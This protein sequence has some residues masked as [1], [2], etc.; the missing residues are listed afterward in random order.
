MS[1]RR[2]I[3]LLLVLCL[4]R[5]GVMAAAFTQEETGVVTA[6][7]DA[8]SGTVAPLL[9]PLGI[10]DENWEGAKEALLAGFRQRKDSIDLSAY[11]LPRGVLSQLVGTI[12]NRE[13]EF[14]YVVQSFQYGYNDAGLVVYLRPTYYSADQRDPAA[15]EAAIEAAVKDAVR[16]DMTDLEKLLALHD[17]LITHCAYDQSLTMVTAYDALVSGSAVCQG[18]T[19]AYRALLD[20]VGI[21]S[22][23]VASE[24]MNHAWNLVELDGNWYHVDVT[25]DDPAPDL[26]GQVNHRFFLLSDEAIATVTYDGDS[27]LH[28]GWE[29]ICIC[30]DT[31]FD[32]GQYWT[33]IRSR[34]LFG[35]DQVACI[36]DGGTDLEV[37]LRGRS[38]GA[39]TLLH[40]QQAQWALS[41]LTGVYYEKAF[42]G[43]SLDGGDYYF[44]TQTGVFRLSADGQDCAQVYTSERSIYGS[45]VESG[46]LRL[47]LASDPK[48][49][50]L[51]LESHILTRYGVVPFTDVVYGRYYYDN[52]GWAYSGG[53]VQGM[54][55]TSFAPEDTCTR[56]QAVTFLHRAAGEPEVT[57]NECPFV[58]VEPGRYYYKAVLWAVEQG[59]VQGVDQTHFAPDD[60]VTRG[61]FVTFLYRLAGTPQVQSTA[62]FVDVAP[63]R[64]YTNPV[65]WAAQSGIV[66]GMDDTHFAPGSPCT[67]GQVVTFLYR[68]FA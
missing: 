62:A 53:I 54:S 51:T 67:R 66:K 58:D 59:I 42:S 30:D 63:G 7:V 45:T 25:W 43:L 6:Y 56:A 64:Y 21:D 65:A 46:I 29:Q 9:A 8:D 40:T 11:S 38:N 4:A 41:G 68:F 52:V 27:N 55:A 18:Y 14:Y 61:H 34:I 3:C 60:T 47:S 16:A 26:Q 31:R 13:P 24:A 35:K 5:P 28:Y 37:V 15:Y 20:R 23:V 33:P 49:T 10:S 44:H 57:A 1:L 36:Q 17:Y 50:D 12:V 19:M 39:L 32:E 48:G 2:L 22:T